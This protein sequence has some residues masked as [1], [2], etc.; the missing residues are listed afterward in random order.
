MRNID[1]MERKLQ[2]IA[3]YYEFDAQLNQV[4]EECGELIQAAAKYNRTKGKG[5]D[6]SMNLGAAYA[7]LVEE[8][9]DVQLVVCQLV[10]LMECGDEVLDVTELKIDRQLKRIG[11]GKRR[12]RMPRVRTMPVSAY[13]RTIFTIRD[14]PRMVCEYEQLKRDVGVRATSYDGLP[15]GG[16]VGSALEEKAAKLLDLEAEINAIQDVMVTIPADMRDGI[17][18]NILYGMRFPLNEY[19]QMVPSLRTWQREKSLFV[20]RAAHALKIY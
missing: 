13:N 1:E 18:N 15:K 16:A 8:L 11:K 9:A 3:D 12:R 6:T 14:Y 20:S 17:M 10:Y 2:Q 4:V 7:N 19:G 5:Y